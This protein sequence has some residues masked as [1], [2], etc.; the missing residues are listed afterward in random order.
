MN[1]KTGKVFTKVPFI[2]R[3]TETRDVCVFR[4]EKKSISVFAHY[5]SKR[6][7]NPGVLNMRIF[8][9]TLDEKLRP[10]HPSPLSC[11]TRIVNIP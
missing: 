11:H 7:T 3:G 4:D 6:L 2:R 5:L 9:C 1:L 8:S 10:V